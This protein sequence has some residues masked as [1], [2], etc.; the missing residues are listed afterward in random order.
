V[1]ETVEPVKSTGKNKGLGN[2][3]APWKPG[4]SGNPAG[5]PKKE[6]CLTSVLKAELSQVPDQLPNSKP[7]SA[8]LTWAQ[9]LG[10]QAIQ[11][12]A[13]GNSPYY[14]EILDRVEGKVTEK[15]E[16]VMETIGPPVIERAGEDKDNNEQTPSET[17]TPP[18]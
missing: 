8:K 18:G 5:R 4:E 17:D 6:N 14:K 7:N 12:A 2:L 3:R 1:S 10:A 11:Q 13:K 16:V 9:I 15:H